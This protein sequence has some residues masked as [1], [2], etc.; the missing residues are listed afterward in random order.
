MNI[1]ENRKYEITYIIR[2]DID[3]AS[4]DKLVKRFDTILKASGAK[5]ASSK[6]WQKRRFA[7]PIDKFTEGTYH[8]INMETDNPAALEEFDRL[9][10]YDG[11]ILRHM[12]VK[13]DYTKEA[14]DD[15]KADK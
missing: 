10:K 8:I 4:K 6:D 3:S 11:N 14:Q 15:K 7:Y 5:I 13:R 9:A 1:M 12:I 2:P